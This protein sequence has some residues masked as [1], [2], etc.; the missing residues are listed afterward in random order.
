MKSRTLVVGLAS[1]LLSI[2]IVRSPAYAQVAQD[3][4]TGVD[5]SSAVRLTD[6]PPSGQSTLTDVSQLVL[7][8]VVDITVNAASGTDG[9]Q[10]S[11]GGAAT[12][13]IVSDDGYILTSSHVASAAS[14]GM[15]VTLDDGRV[16]PAS[17]VGSDVA[18]DASVLKIDVSGLPTVILGDSNEVAPGQPVLV[19]GNALGQY[20]NTLS[21]GIVSGVN[22]SVQ[23]GDESGSGQTT[24]LNGL[25]QT[26]ASINVG[27]SGGPLVD[28][29]TGAVI[30]VNSA[31]VPF[32]QGV[33]FAVPINQD[34]ALIDQYIGGE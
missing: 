28:A 2:G 23:I 14:N 3:T 34:K 9:T 25:I 6:W 33:G 29:R 7:P 32:A 13:M 20:H 4:V 8:A 26:D 16:F 5:K 15:T 1:V 19:I 10:N 27:D 31:I 12:G 18:H 11:Q 24:T 30:G 17:V 22:R 21:Q